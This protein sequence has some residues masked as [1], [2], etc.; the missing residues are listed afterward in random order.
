MSTSGT[1]LNCC[2]GFGRPALN[3]L[4]FPAALA[5]LLDA[6]HRCT[7]PVGPDGKAVCVI[8][9]ASVWGHP[10]ESCKL[11]SHSIAR[12]SVVEH[13]IMRA[14]KATNLHGLV[15]CEPSQ[16][17]FREPTASGGT[18]LFRP[19]DVLVHDINRSGDLHFFDITFYSPN[20]Q[21]VANAAVIASVDALLEPVTVAK[22]TKYA[23]IIA[24]N[25][26][27]RFHFDPLAFSTKGK[28]SSA[29]FLSLR[30]LMGVGHSPDGQAHLSKLMQ[31]ISYAAYTCAATFCLAQ[32]GSIPLGAKWGVVAYTKD[33][34]IPPFPQDLMNLPPVVDDI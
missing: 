26:V 6:S 34:V 3:N 5:F 25:G 18:R 12:H 28:C 21:A 23:D 7:F 33:P 10:I 31:D 8:C 13:I 16:N 14:A 29:T 24:R 1:F 2:P 30:A 4:I 27:G 22:S 32:S 9:N 20:Q 19:A 15:E 11:T 17:T